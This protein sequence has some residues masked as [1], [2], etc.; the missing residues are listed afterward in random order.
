MH[1]PKS[2]TGVQSINDHLSSVLMVL[3]FP[4]YV[5]RFA[6]YLYIRLSVNAKCEI[7]VELEVF[8]GRFW[9]QC[10]C[11]GPELEN[12]INRESFSLSAG[13]SLGMI[14]LGKGRS[15]FGLKSGASFTSQLCSYIKGGANP[16]MNSQFTCDQIR[17][18]ENINLLVTSP[19]ASLATGLIFFNTCSRSIADWFTPPETALTI[20]TI[21]PEHLLLH[22]VARAL[23]CWEEILFTSEWVCNN[24]PEFLKS[25]FSRAIYSQQEFED[26]N[27]DFSCWQAYCNI[28]AGSCFSIGLRFSG[29]QNKGAFTLVFKFLEVFLQLFDSGR[30][31]DANTG[32]R[33]VFTCLQT[34]LTALCMIMSGSGNLQ[35]LAVIRRLHCLVGPNI[36]YGQQMAVHMALG[37]L[38]LGGCR[39]SLRNDPEAIAALLAAF[40][41]T[42]PISSDDNRYH[43]QAFRHL[44]VK[45]CEPRLLLTR[46][47]LSYQVEQALVKIVLKE[48]KHYD[49]FAFE[50]VTPCLVPQLDLIS[51]IEVVN[52]YPNFGFLSIQTV[53]DDDKSRND[54]AWILKSCLFVQSLSN[55]TY[56]LYLSSNLKIK[57][58]G[59][60][61]TSTCNLSNLNQNK[62]LFKIDSSNLDPAGF[63]VL[64]CNEDT[65]VGAFMESFKLSVESVNRSIITMLDLNVKTRLDPFAINAQIDKNNPNTSVHD[66]AFSTKLGTSIDSVFLSQSEECLQ[67]T[68]AVIKQLTLFRLFHELFPQNSLFP[69]KYQAEK[70]TELSVGDSINNPVASGPPY[71]NYSW[72]RCL[73]A[74]ISV[75]L[76]KQ[77]HNCVRD[78]N[79]SVKKYLLTNPSSLKGSKEEP[80]R[81]ITSATVE[82]LPNVRPKSARLRNNS[83]LLHKTSD[84]KPSAGLAESN[85]RPYLIKNSITESQNDG[86]LSKLGDLQAS[87]SI[88]FELNELN[89]LTNLLSM[90]GISNPQFIRAAVLGSLSTTGE[91]KSVE[92]ILKNDCGLFESAVQF[93]DRVEQG[94]IALTSTN[95]PGYNS[96]SSGASSDGGNARRTSS[97]V[98]SSY[99]VSCNSEIEKLPP[100]QADNFIQF[101]HILSS[102]LSVSKGNGIKTTTRK[103]FDSNTKQA[104]FGGAFASLSDHQIS[105]LLHTLCSVSVSPALKD[106]SQLTVS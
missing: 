4:Q 95:Q 37:L 13:L 60:I 80:P 89:T 87:V 91:E 9:D 67:N 14:M 99:S 70:S 32:S 15:L 103:D 7:T 6:S 72:L 44:Y 96:E 30:G 94:K 86:I 45:A 46:N 84:A 22:V 90:L 38:F 102:I 66:Q 49:E 82:Q 53:L 43:L 85:L 48:T 1:Q 51:R 19:G 71:E 77:F 8:M 65:F 100:L 52:K 3:S 92:R 26:E 39:Y 42:Y 27:L 105:M 76:I 98:F 28:I 24:L 93:R 29:S 31:F 88:K 47:V 16:H 75:K 50:T 106:L 57:P 101:D 56:N 17:E 12:C 36:D 64:S 97:G 41:P 54:F 68:K 79:S 25:V 61:C 11:L 74:T 58:P 55:E 33:T 23:V 35:V 18:G 78:E 81:D 59:S 83:T 104:C 10:V 69:R 34:C 73:T 5:V 63:G 21:L 20:D 40:Y 2:S 62:Q